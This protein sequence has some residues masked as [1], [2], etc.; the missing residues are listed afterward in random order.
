MKPL[1]RP[2]QR[3]IMLNRQ[4]MHHLSSIACNSYQSQRNFC[5]KFEKWTS[6]KKF[7]QFCFK[8]SAQIHTKYHP[9]E[10]IS[11]LVVLLTNVNSLESHS[12]KY[13]TQVVRMK[14]C[15]SC[16]YFIGRQNLTFGC[17]THRHC[18][19]R[20]QSSSLQK[21]RPNAFWLIHKNCS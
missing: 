7:L 10:V 2:T 19:S 17:H 13:G 21:H 11:I 5:S 18:Y 1:S 8:M 20:I 12:K 3:K 15:D 4:I 6:M 9:F 16:I 14:F